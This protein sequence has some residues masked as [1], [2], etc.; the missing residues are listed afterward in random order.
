[1]VIVVDIRFEEEYQHFIF[2]T[3]KRITA[4]YPQH[5]FIF[6]FDKPFDTSFIF[7]KNV[8]AVVI[9]PQKISLLNDIKISFALKKYNAEVLVTAKFVSQTKVPQCLIAFKKMTS[10]SL[11]KAQEVVT[12][13]EFLKKEIVE[14]HKIN[15]GKIDVVY[16]GIEEISQPVT[17]QQKESIKERY[18]LGNEYFLYTGII[19]SGN[20][21]LNLLKAFSAFKKM[22]KSNMQLLIATKTDIPKEFLETLRL[23]KFKTEVQLLDVDE[24]ELAKITKSAYAFVY[25]FSQRYLYAQQA[26]QSGVPILTSNAGYMPEVCGDAALYFDQTDHKK[27]ADKMMIVYKDE[28]ARKQLIEKGRDQIK[29][30]SWDSSA[31]SLWKCIEKACR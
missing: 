14:K 6:I 11:G 15:G 16:K 30:Y 24:N 23:F 31:D 1:M 5:S 28:N 9:N 4:Q 27:I 18:A 8:T 13:S 12:D 25:P 22:Q 17:F 21:L 2:K 29:K 19:P 7:S 26:M 3:F 10:K 20:N